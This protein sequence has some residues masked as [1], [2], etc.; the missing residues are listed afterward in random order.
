MHL[1]II[2]TYMLCTYKLEEMGVHLLMA[3]TNTIRNKFNAEQHF[4]SYLQL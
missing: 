3:I 1:F 2:R 4:F